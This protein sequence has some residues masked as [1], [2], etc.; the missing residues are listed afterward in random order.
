MTLSLGIALILESPETYIECK[1]G[2]FGG[3]GADFLKGFP[4]GASDTE[5]AC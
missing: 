1:L 2:Y 3:Q 5:S 4:G